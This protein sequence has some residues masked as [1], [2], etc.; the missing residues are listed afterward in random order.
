MGMDE[1][2]ADRARERPAVAQPF[3]SLADAAA[4]QANE[5]TLLAWIRTG[6]SL[7]TFG[8][9][10]ARLGVWIRIVGDAGKGIPGSAWLGAVFVFMGA[11]LDAIGI[12]RYIRFHRAFVRRQPVPVNVTAVLTIAAAIALLGAL[13]GTFVILSLRS[14]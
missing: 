3:G 14:R 9:V 4:I 10:I 13:L 12:T 2:D 7:V 6:L 8:F 1:A 11:A 5:R